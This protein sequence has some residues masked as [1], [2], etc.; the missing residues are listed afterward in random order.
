MDR[1]AYP[2]DI[3]DDEWAF[4]PPYLT[5]MTEEAP[6]RLYSLRE[7][8][9]GLRWLVR[10]G[11]PWRMMPNELPPW[12]AVY[13]QTQRWLKAG[14]FEAMVHDWR[15][16]LRLAEGRERQP[17]AAIFDRRT[18]QSTP[19]SGPRAGYDGAKRKRGSKVHIALDTFFKDADAETSKR[20]AS[21]AE[22]VIN[23]R[24]E[25]TSWPC[26][27]VGDSGADLYTQSP[28]TSPETESNPTPNAIMSSNSLLFMTTAPL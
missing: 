7:V 18:L 20:F 24:K 17:S 8:F 4:V 13:Q 19:E 25:L 3:S 23:S 10:G 14:V 15:V 28:F 26:P 2:S 6:R 11:A 5:L 16:M 21:C 9:N 12:E 22:S 1:K 27:T